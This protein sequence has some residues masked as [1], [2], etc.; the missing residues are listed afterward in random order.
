M[1]I[2]DSEADFQTD[3]DPA[4]PS[5]FDEHVDEELY[6]DVD[7]QLL[8]LFEDYQ[9]GFNDFDAE[10]ILDCFALPVTIWQFGKGHIFKDDDEIHENVTALLGAYEKEGVVYSRFDI[11]S[12]HVS[13]AA[14]MATLQW[15][16]EDAEGH[17][18]FEFS[19]H[20]H[21]IKEDEDWCIA[22]VCNE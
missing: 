2:E 16:Q 11:L 5:A 17:S 13:G 1:S 6:E 9:A 22:L 4:Y 3:L 8:A 21:L 7:E 20:Y 12:W 10:Q 14:A 19:C 18:I 15:R